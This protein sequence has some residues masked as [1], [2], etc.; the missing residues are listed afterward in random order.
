[1]TAGLRILWAA[2]L[3]ACAAEFAFFAVVDPHDLAILGRPV[4]AG[5]MAIYTAG[6]FVF[7]C[8]GAASAALTRFLARDPT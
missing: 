3:V 1:V 5:R 6:F 4:E 2:F 8:V 7:W